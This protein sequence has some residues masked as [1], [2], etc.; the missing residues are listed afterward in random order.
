MKIERK[1]T[2]GTGNGLNEI[3]YTEFINALEK[4][5]KFLNK[6]ISHYKKTGASKMFGSNWYA[7]NNWHGEYKIESY[8]DNCFPFEIVNRVGFNSWGDIE[9]GIVI[10]MKLKAPTFNG[11]ETENM[12]V[13]FCTHLNV[14][15]LKEFVKKYELQPHILKE[16]LFCAKEY[17]LNKIKEQKE[18]SNAYIERELKK[19]SQLNDECKVIETNLKENIEQVLEIDKFLAGRIISGKIIK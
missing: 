10:P 4:E 12:K 16:V 8:A 13:V 18:D 7:L 11:G 2:S 5:V 3:H 15:N 6:F 9:L 19:L 14:R 17:Y 1:F